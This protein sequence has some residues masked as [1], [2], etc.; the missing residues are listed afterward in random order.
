MPLAHKMSI[1]VEMHCEDDYPYDECWAYCLNGSRATNKN[2]LR[3]IYEVLVMIRLGD[4]NE[5]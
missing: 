4:K 2:P 3:A 5:H 1:S